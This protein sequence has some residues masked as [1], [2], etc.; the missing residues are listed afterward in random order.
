MLNQKWANIMPKEVENWI[1]D[2]RQDVQFIDVREVSEY[3]AEHI[4]GFKL[5]P[6]SQLEVR[7]DEIDRN[8]ETVVICRSGGRSYNACEFLSSY[9]YSKLYNMIGGMMAWQSE[10]VKG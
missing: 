6:L 7:Y 9:G 2:Q 8:K 10:T 5:I 4:E 1:R 3:R